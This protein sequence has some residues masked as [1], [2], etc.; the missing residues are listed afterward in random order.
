MPIT[1]NF[2]DYS[3][4]ALLQELQELHLKYELLSKSHE[5]HVAESNNIHE[6]LRKSEDKFRKAFITSP[7]SVNIN[8]LSDGMYISINKGFTKISGYTE[9]EV[10]GKTSLELNIWADTADRDKLVKKLLEEGYVENLETFFLM[11][12]GSLRNGI[13]SASIIDLEGIPHILSITRD[14]TDR[15]YAEIALYQSENKYRELIEL[16]VDGILLG[17]SDGTLISANSYILNLTGRS[18]DQLLG[19]NISELFSSETLKNNPLRFDLLQKGETVINER[20]IIRPDGRL[21]PVEMHTKMM[22]D[23]TYQSIFHDITERKEAERALLESEEWFRNTFEQAGDGI[24]YLN[25][26]GKIIA[27]NKSFAEMHGYTVE[28]IRN[29]QMYDLDCPEAK[30]FYMERMQLLKEGETLKFEVEHYHKAGHR[31]PLEVTAKRLTI[32][33]EDYIMSTHRDINERLKIEAAMKIAREKAEASDRLKTSFLNNISHEVRTPLNGILGFAEIISK[34]DLTFEE[35]TEAILMVHESS[36]RLLETITNYMDISLLVSGEM[37]VK[38]RE[39]SPDYVLRKIFNKFTPLASSKKN[40]FVL[41]MPAMSDKC[42]INSDPEFIHK[43]L[44]HLLNNSIKFTE[45]GAIRFGF[46]IQ[47]NYLEFFVSD[48]GIGIGQDSLNRVFNS[49][50]KEEQIKNRP[51]EGSGLGLSI[52]KGLIELLGGELRVETEKGRGAKFFFS[53]PLLSIVKEK[54]NVSNDFTSKQRVGLSTILIAED[55][56]INFFYIRTLLQRSTA[57]EIIRAA[58]GRE[59]IEK[60]K[61]NPGIDLIL[62]DMKMPEVDGFEATR[63]IRQLN[64]D[65]PIIAITAYAMA[66]D[67]ESVLSSGC[68]GYLSKPISGKSLLDKIGEFVKVQNLRVL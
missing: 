68:D 15:R 3:K 8:R 19:M 30:E 35:R 7:D 65:V 54:S 11:K 50:E 4:D 18:L 49:F 67:E 39:F 51:S 1:V 66:G 2:Q 20:S 41:N 10:I 61:S 58:N 34:T 36:S 60:F 33:S 32:G 9:E 42:L 17:S 45:N 27:V 22:P 5:K 48:T 21:I 47:G 57:A 29:M 26:D 28:E 38:K 14:I 24:L 6:E 43:I 44:T 31:I 46:T 55:D 13:M 16:A 25:Y 64:S 12:N 52:S 63:Q 37:I 53:Q 56:E 62:M 23:G 40:D 59:A